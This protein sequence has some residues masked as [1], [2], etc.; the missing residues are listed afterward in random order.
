MR[1]KSLQ[2]TGFKSFVDRTTFTFENGVTAVVGPNGCG[3]SNVADAVRWVM[4]EQSALRL[5]G[6]VMEDVIFG[7][8]ANRPPVGMAEVVLSFENL[9]GRAPA[10]YA[11]YSEIE[12]CRRLYRSGESEYLINKSP[13]RL[14][15]VNDFFRDSGVGAKGNTIIEQGKVAEIVSARAEDRRLLIEEAAGITKY[16]AR[17]R[18]AESKIRS[19]EQNLDRIKDVLGE[20][21][22]Q[23]SSLERQARKAARYK[24]F[25]ETQRIL[26]L[27]VARDERSELL[28]AAGE[29]KAR[30]ISLRDQ[31]TALSAGLAERE[32]ALE[33][34]RIKLTEADKAV[35]QG[36]ESLY[37]LRSEIK[38]LEG[39]IELGR[40]EC[41]NIGE[42]N[43]G[44]RQELDQLRAQLTQVEAEAVEAREELDQLEQAVQGQQ[45]TVDGAEAEVGQAREE[46]KAGEDERETASQRLVGVL[47]SIARSEDRLAGL[48]DRRAA[49][50]QR[51]R[52][53]DRDDEDQ[54]T[55]AREL[56]GEQTGLEEGL[57][58]LLG[59]RDRFQ[60]Q[61]LSAMRHHERS[62][63]KLAEA[64]ASLQAKREHLGARSARLASL[65]ELLEGNHDLAPG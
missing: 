50:D 58:N 34:K 54:Q 36:S 46:L 61:L 21:R 64:T 40:R 29:A 25:K 53:A 20:I 16:K 49:I 23:I 55:A 15:D 18:E 38:N 57:R 10:E 28:A 4:G 48:G 59:E 51:L 44:R 52:V 31:V 27:S 2:L 8:S 41:E 26:E 33:E 22:R 45:V 37:A 12:I 13:V 60:E 3:K 39:Q 63:E 17:R 19:T 43:E 56:V 1:I 62:A 11:D 32:L 6:K 42:S 30:N 24:R 14:K 5:R 7:G 47:T 9:Q 65:K 35:S